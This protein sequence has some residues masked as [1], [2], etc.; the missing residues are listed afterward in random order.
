MATNQRKYGRSTA[1]LLLQLLLQV[2][3]HSGDGSEAS[4]V[5]VANTFDPN[6]TTAFQA[7]A[8]TD[9]LS[10]F[11]YDQNRATV[12]IH[13]YCMVATSDFVLPFGGSDL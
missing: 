9:P 13:I 10:Y 7:S 8:T 6:S 11:R 5:T 4:N 2:K 3:A 1:V 12:L